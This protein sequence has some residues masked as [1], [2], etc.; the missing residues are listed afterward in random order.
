MTQ[1]HK[2]ASNKD[3]ILDKERVFLVQ[4]VAANNL[5]SAAK[6]LGESYSSKARHNIVNN[7]KTG[8]IESGVTP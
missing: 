6:R 1:C 7:L 2:N 3:H 5:T 4:L 8:P